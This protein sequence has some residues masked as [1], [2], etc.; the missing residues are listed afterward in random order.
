MSKVGTLVIQYTKYHVSHIPAATSRRVSPISDMIP[1]RYVLFASFRPA[2][3]GTITKNNSVLVFDVC[4]K[5]SQPP[6][7]VLLCNCGGGDGGGVV[8]SSGENCIQNKNIKSCLNP[9]RSNEALAAYLHIYFSLQRTARVR[10]RHRHRAILCRF[11][12]VFNGK[13]IERFYH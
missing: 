9:L 1:G 6:A 13:R 3:I 5:K 11:V 12:A 8:F 4:G 2:P 10:V 7:S